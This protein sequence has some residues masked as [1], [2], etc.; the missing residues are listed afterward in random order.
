MTVSKQLAVLLAAASAS[1][2][3]AANATA[4]ATASAPGAGASAFAA[5]D[6]EGFST[7]RLALDYLPLYASRY[8]LAGVVAGASRFSQDGWRRDTRQLGAMYR[9]LDP[10][11]LDGVQVEGGYNRQ[12]GHG[13]LTL[14]ANYHA[15]L[16]PKRSVELFLNRDWVE[17]RRALDGAVAFTYAGA[18]LEQGLG[19]HVTVVGMLGYQDFTDGNT[20]RHA[21][22]RLIVQPSLD[23]GLTLQARYRVFHSDA[24]I[25]PTYFNPE[26]YDETMLAVGWRKR[27]EGWVG[28]VTAGVGRQR[29]GDAGR[30]PSR[31]LEVGLESPQRQRQSV[32]LRAGY[33][34]SASFG[35]PDYRYRYAQAEWLVGF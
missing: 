32:R 13:L 10:A 11:T 16:A 29:V 31:L 6:S 19:E 33:N 34:N 8:E 15:T 25:A 20:R 22:A 21:R 24:D 17:T 14:D 5:T 30:T 7:Q 2:A 18:A 1:G 28:N 26:R 3:F 23:L 27:F 12:G 9:K 4:N 35:G